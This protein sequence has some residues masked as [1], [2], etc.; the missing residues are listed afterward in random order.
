MSSSTDLNRPDVLRMPELR[1]VEATHD[2]ARAQGYAV[3][4]AQGRRDAAAAVRAEAEQQAAAVAATEARREAEH[5]A[6][7]AALHEAAAQA[8]RALAETCRRVDEQASVMA[9]ELTRELVG[10]VGADPVHLLDRVIGLLP[11]HAVVSVRLNPAIAAVAGELADHGITV[12]ADPSLA[13]GDA[14]A[15]AEDHVVDL[16]VDETIARLAEV[17]R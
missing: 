10:A 8:H 2:S 17:L 13:L 6:A 4:W 9:L 14:V 5:A 3:G 7:V 16:R 12:V 11:H 15:H 1:T